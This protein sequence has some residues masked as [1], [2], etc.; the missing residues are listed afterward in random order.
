[1]CYKYVRQAVERHV[2]DLETGATFGQAESVKVLSRMEIFLLGL[3]GFRGKGKR[4]KVL[5]LSVRR[6][7]QVHATVVGA[8]ADAEA[9][10]RHAL[11]VLGGMSAGALVNDEQRAVGQLH[12]LAVSV[13]MVHEKAVVFRRRNPRM[14]AVGAEDQPQ[15]TV[16]GCI[17]TMQAHQ[18]ES[19]TRLPRDLMQPF[20]ARPSP[21]AGPQRRF[22]R[23]RHRPVR[24]NGVSRNRLTPKTLCRAPHH[25]G[26]GGSPGRD[27]GNSATWRPQLV[28]SLAGRSRY[29]TRPAGP[30]YGRRET[31][32]VGAVRNNRGRYATSTDALVIRGNRLTPKPPALAPPV[33]GPW[34]W[35]A[36]RLALMR[37]PRDRL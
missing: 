6:W 34:D 33:A 16:A 21:P 13:A 26:C 37:M 17:T 20:L 27:F 3:S 7:K 28:L 11:G 10:Q 14:S 9:A 22:R 19:K 25:A 2:N 24:Y 23:P 15:S 1:M 18:P 31:P 35:K 30:N 36:A 8:D 12:R 32:P 29:P 4:F 5:R